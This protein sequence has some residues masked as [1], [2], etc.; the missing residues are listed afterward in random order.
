MA[1]TKSP[2]SL[3]LN[4]EMSWFL[5]FQFSRPLPTPT[6]PAPAYPSHTLDVGHVLG[7]RMVPGEEGMVAETAE[8]VGTWGL[9]L[10]GPQCLS[11]QLKIHDPWDHQLSLWPAVPVASWP[12]S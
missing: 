4:L 1:L 3:G 11:D 5:P 9:G 12:V 7:V 10:G 8:A 2:S 6:C